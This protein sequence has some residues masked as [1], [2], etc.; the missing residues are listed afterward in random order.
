MT[1]RLN[2]KINY[3][4]SDKAA[5]EFVAYYTNRDQDQY[6]LEFEVRFAQT[7]K[8]MQAFFNATAMNS[9]AKKDGD[10]QRNR[11]LPQFISSGGLY[12]QRGDFDATI[13]GK[14][15]AAK[16]KNGPAIP[17]PL[18]DFFTLDVNLGWTIGKTVLTRFY[19]ET[20][21]LTDQAYS[22]VVGYPDFGRTITVG[23]RQSFK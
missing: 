22:T 2:L 15:V 23:L 16:P 18:G 3:K 4:L 10:M 6:G 13:L 17:R 14:Y 20:K 12:F 8:S 9:R 5:T 7:F 19:L 11:E 21:N 1:R